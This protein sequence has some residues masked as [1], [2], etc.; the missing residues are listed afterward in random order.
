MLKAVFLRLSLFA[1]LLA[2][3]C[4]SKTTETPR[5]PPATNDDPLPPQPPAPKKDAAATPDGPVVIQPQPDAGPAK[6]SNGKACAADSDCQSGSC[7]DGVCCSTACRNTCFSCKL[8]GFEGMCLPVPAGQ[9]PEEE[10]TQTAAS[11]CGNDG[12]CDGMG[13]CRKHPAG[14]E[15][16]PAACNG[17]SETLPRTC[18]GAGTC[19]PAVTRPCVAGCAA[20]SCPTPCSA[21]NPCASGTFCDAGMCKPKRSTGVACASADECSTG[22]CVDGVC[23]ASSCGGTCQ[24]CNLAGSMGSCSPVPAMLDPRNNCP[25][26]LGSTCGRMGGC[27]G[28]GACRLYPQGTS[29]GAKT[30]NGATETSA[31]SCNGTGMCVT[32]NMTRSCAPFRCAANMCG[33]SCVNSNDCDTGYVCTGTTCI[34]A[35]QGPVLHW[36][37]DETDPSGTTALDSSGNGHDGTFIGVTEFPKPSNDVPNLGSASNPR[38]RVFVRTGQQAVRLQNMPADVKPTTD[39]TVTVWYKA[40]TID[41]TGAELVSAG[42]NYILRLRSNQLEFTKRTAGGLAQCIVNVPTALNGSWH[43]VAGLTGPSGIKLYF[44]GVELAVPGTCNRT[45]AIAYTTLSSDLFVGRHGNGNGAYDFDGNIDDVRI[46]N[47]A[48]STAEI[49]ALYQPPVAQ[50]GLKLHWKF[51][52]TDVNTTT[53]L[54]ASGNN[55]NG[56]YIGATTFPAPSAE[57]P[58][59]GVGVSNPSSRLFTRAS[60][61]AVRLQAMPA[62]LKPANDVT[63]TAWFKS[64]SADTMGAELVSAGDNYVLRIRSNQVEFSKRLTSGTS[65]CVGTATNNLN[66]AWHHVAGVNTAAGLKVYFDGADVTPGTCTNVEAIQYNSGSNDLFVGRHGNGS[67]EFDFDGNIDDVR[68]YDRALS[69]AEIAAL[70][71]PPPVAS[72]L[73][74]HWKFDETDAVTTTAADASGNAFNGTYVGVTGI[75]APSTTDVPVLGSGILNPAA[76]VFDRANRQA[77]QLANV[78][79]TL[80]PLNELTVAAWYKADSVDTTGSEIVSQGDNYILRLRPTQLEFSKRAAGGFAQCFATIANNA[81]LDNAWHHLAGVTSATGG[82]KIYLDG[83]DVTPG[84]CNRTDDIAY[85]AVNDLFVG[86]HGNGSLNFDFGGSIDDVRIYTRALPAAE[87]TT[88]SGH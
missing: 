63:V 39:L 35:S 56:T 86:R 36:K 80:K 88:L 38:S 78:S 20:N 84:T 11:T 7:A 31:G 72:G 19:Q 22:N 37:F 57:V 23:C 21:Q 66:N 46:Y 64:S 71:Q 5:I 73:A 9:D 32:S 75:P 25:T 50:G 15:C 33:T 60:Q 10:C 18:D 47:R 41:T 12:W 62:P 85:N 82:L 69:G 6:T 29:C 76:R 8:S 58:N 40:T 42:D 65:V 48:L 45:E 4:G 79:T 51:D 77:V 43:H 30:C 67:N 68:I 53:A 2:A 70:Y 34:M 81:H 52:E 24:A 54:D 16:A 13:G 55:Y 28:A 17:M 74:L 1:S 26:E 87:I 27:D 59:L 44:D 61:H 83:V 14:F 3:G 49:A